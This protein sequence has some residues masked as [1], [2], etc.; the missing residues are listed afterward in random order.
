MLKLAEN[1]KTVLQIKTASVHS[2]VSS[3]SGGNQQ[4]TVLARWMATRPAIILADEP[5]RGISI[6]NKIE[7]YKLVRQL[8]SQGAAIVIASSEFEELVGLCD[9]VFIIRDGVTEG[10]IEVAGLSAE[11]LLEAVLAKSSRRPDASQG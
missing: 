6:V 4:K 5:T 9:R 3:L 11:D 7:I 10:E 1:F 8:A 2:A